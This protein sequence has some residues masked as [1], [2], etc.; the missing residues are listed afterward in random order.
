MTILFV[1]YT[2]FTC[3]QCKK[4]LR[5][6]GK[7]FKYLI[8]PSWQLAVSQLF[9]AAIPFTTFFFLANVGFKTLIG[10]G[11]GISMCNIAGISV[12][13]AIALAVEE[14]ALKKESFKDA[15]ATIQKGLLFCM[16]VV[17]LPVFALWMNAS[18]LLLKLKQNED[19]IK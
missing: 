3:Q 6:F 13:Y 4:K 9:L 8:K 12:S 16:V 17:C 11:L 7:G 14:V 5:L 2:A 15:V 10:S 19:V 18:N 1:F